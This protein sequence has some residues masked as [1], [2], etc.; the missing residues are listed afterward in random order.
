MR[1]VARIYTVSVFG[2]YVS[3]IRC[4][5]LISAISDRFSKNLSMYWTRK[6]SPKRTQKTYRIYII[7]SLKPPSK[8]S[9]LR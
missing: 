1:R 3:K 4:L 6:S 7:Y 9:I 5:D 8:R 2:V